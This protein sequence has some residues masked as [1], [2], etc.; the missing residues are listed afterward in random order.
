MAGIY[1]HIPFCYSRCIYCGF[2]SSVG[3]LSL[4][5]KYVD[6]LLHEN[7]L[8]KVYLNNEPVETAYI[9]G[10]TPSLLCNDNIRRIA[11]AIYH[12]GVTKEFTMECN[13]D[14]VTP[15]LCQTLRD[16]GVNRVSMG[17]QTFSDD[18]LRFLNRRHSS[19]DVP[20][21]IQHLRDAGINNISID[22]MFGFPQESM[23]EWEADIDKALRL[24]V[25]HIS[26]YSLMYEEGTKL[27]AMLEKGEIKENEENVSAEMYDLLI[28]KLTQNGYEH[29]EISNFAK[30]GYRSLHNSSYWN[31]TKYL[32]LGAAAHSY[33]TAS[34]QW[35]ISNVKEYI[36]SIEA[37]AI[38]F[39]K[40]TIDE[41]TRYNDMV[42]TTLRTKDG[43][44][45]TSLT[46]EDYIYILRNARKSIDAGTLAVTNNRLHLT[47]KGLYISDDIMSDL[48]RVDE[49]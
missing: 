11:E 4:Q 13:P 6:A 39:E 30:P 1:V 2:Y 10:G 48:I 22:L 20:L 36:K 31:G 44:D 49:E 41:Q 43:I 17:V 37:D 25:Q 21:A 27:Y 16:C 33:D 26:A 28:E 15:E 46:H 42:T 38:P 32:G 7:E 40:E 24:D 12:K 19:N 9:G 45:L 47:R 8:R 3:L 14:D 18:R 23:T 35:N 34:R 5:D 29:Y